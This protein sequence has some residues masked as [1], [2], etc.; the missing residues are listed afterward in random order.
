M[1]IIFHFICSGNDRVQT[2]TVIDS[3]DMFCI[4][5]RQLLDSNPALTV[6]WVTQETDCL[7]PPTVWWDKGGGKQAR[8]QGLFGANRWPRSTFCSG[9]LKSVLT[10]LQ[11]FLS[12]VSFL[13]DLDS[14]VSSEDKWHTCNK[15]KCMLIPQLLKKWRGV[16]KIYF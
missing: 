2:V 6:R 5:L 15:A 16:S 3:A 7:K 12:S 14:P 13:H 10:E 11:W 9:S 8:A 4:W 1:E